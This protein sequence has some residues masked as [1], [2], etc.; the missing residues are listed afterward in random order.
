MDVAMATKAGRPQYKVPE[1][2]FWF[3]ESGKR[4][5]CGTFVKN[6]HCPSTNEDAKD[7]AYSLGCRGEPCRVSHNKYQDQF[8]YKRNKHSR[9]TATAVKN[10]LEWLEKRG[11]VM[12][13]I[14]AKVYCNPKSIWEIKSGNRKKVSKDL[15]QAILG[16]TLLDEDIFISK[17]RGNLKK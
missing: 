13:R 14:A 8:R 17:Q 16:L 11:A 4:R 6:D 15:G 12:R 2:R 1:E 5:L 10:H 7:T 9:M 3:D